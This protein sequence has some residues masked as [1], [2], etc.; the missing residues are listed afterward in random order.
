[1]KSRI[2]LGGVPVRQSGIEFIEKRLTTVLVFVCLPCVV[3]EVALAFDVRVLQVIRPS[4][5][6][7]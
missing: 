6:L 1:M 5:K 2:A 7:A 3:I 4:P